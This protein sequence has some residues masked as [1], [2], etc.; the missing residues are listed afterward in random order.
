MKEIIVVILVAIVVLALVIYAESGNDKKQRRENS[1]LATLMIR[2]S[3]PANLINKYLDLPRGQEFYAGDSVLVV[4]RGTYGQPLKAY[5]RVV[6]TA[7]VLETKI[8]F[9]LTVKK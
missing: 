6:D 9:D 2:A 3:I 7:C 8:I 1:E 4:E 5:I